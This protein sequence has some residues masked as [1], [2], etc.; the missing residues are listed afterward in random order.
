MG[1]VVVASLISGCAKQE[2]QTCSVSFEF[3]NKMTS[4]VVSLVGLR[5][6]RVTSYVETIELRSEH[7]Y[8]IN[9]DQR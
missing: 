1:S 5:C 7:C 6:Q 4:S 3:G 8:L 9:I 2:S